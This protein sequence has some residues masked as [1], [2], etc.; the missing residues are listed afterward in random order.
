VLAGFGIT[1]V[2]EGVVNLYSK[3][4]VF[5]PLSEAFAFS[6]IILRYRKKENYTPVENFINLSKKIFGYELKAT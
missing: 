2:N 5:I 6:S 4:L 1:I 3:D